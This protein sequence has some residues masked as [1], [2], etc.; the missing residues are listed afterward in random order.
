M[1]YLTVGYLNANVNRKTWKREPEIRTDGSR[2]TQQN[3]QIDR[4]GY[5]FCLAKSSWSGFWI[6]LERNWTG[7]LVQ[8]WTAGGL[9]GPIGN[10]VSQSWKQC[11]ETL[12]YL[13]N[14]WSCAPVMV[15]HIDW[16]CQAAG[17]RSIKNPIQS[18]V[19][20]FVGNFFSWFEMESSI[21]IHLVAI[22]SSGFPSNYLSFLI[23]LASHNGIPESFISFYIGKEFYFPNLTVSA[24]AVDLRNS[25]YCWHFH[26]HLWHYHLLH[27]H[28]QHC[29][30]H[31][32][33]W[34]LT[35]WMPILYPL[36][37]IRTILYRKDICFLGEHSH[38]VQ[39]D[40]DVLSDWIGN[41]HGIIQ[42]IC[43]LP[44]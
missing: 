44:V 11:F 13:V 40:R 23:L 33:I 15:P 41:R 29:F 9:P 39:D 17:Y 34:F 3:P 12:V 6:D 42:I 14:D 22:S 20:S 38:V 37:S 32:L 36:D 30:R 35:V 5:G 21:V 7:F 26:S 19:L 24:V 18:I 25:H 31:R 28:L 4:Y 43:I 16:L 27:C 10:T 1:S 8:T 2:Q